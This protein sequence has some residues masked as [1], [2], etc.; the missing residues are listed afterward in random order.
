MYTSTTYFLK[1]QVPKATLEILLNHY[2]VELQYQQISSINIEGNCIIFFNSSFSFLPRNHG[3]QF[4]AFTKGKIEIEE[5]EKYFIVK[6]YG[7]TSRLFTLPGVFALIVLTLFS[8]NSGISAGVLLF[9]LVAF[10]LVLIPQLIALYV[11]F[12]VYFEQL[13]NDIERSLQ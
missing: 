13:R 10:F 4:N 2:R 5:N 6:A 8:L 7:D 3:N 1:G 12:P 9:S 11:Y